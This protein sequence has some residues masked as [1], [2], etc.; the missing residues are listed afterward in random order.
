VGP[1]TFNFAE[2]TERAITAGAALRVADA[3]ELAS[4]VAR[5]LAADA[6]RD[7]MRRAALAF[8]EAHRGAT[9]RLWAWLAPRLDANARIDG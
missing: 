9:D 3:R 2:V 8:V 4:T 1:H 6:E 7:R 5:L